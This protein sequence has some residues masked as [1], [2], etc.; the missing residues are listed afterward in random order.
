MATSRV[1]CASF[2]IGTSTTISITRDNKAY[3]HTLTY[4]FG[5]AT[6]TIAT[7]T[8]QTTVV[9]NPT[10]STL[11]AQIPNAVSGYGTIT[12]Q[13]YNG[14]TLVGTSTAGF[15]AYAVKSNC[16]PTVAA[17]IVDTN[18][19]TRNLTG[20]DTSGN[21]TKLIRYMS[22]PRVTI[23]AT[24]KNSATIK[25]YQIY[26]PGGLMATTSPYTFDTTYGAEWRCTAND[27]RG[28]STTTSYTTAFVEYDPCHFTTPPVIKRTESTSTTATITLKGYCFKGNFGA[29]SNTL[30][31]K[32]RY[33]T[34]TGSYGSYVSVTPTWNTDGTFTATAN[35]PNLS[36]AEQYTFEVIAQDKLTSFGDGE[37][38][39]LTQGIG[40]LRIAKDYV[41]AKNNLIVGDKDNED[42]RCFKARRKREGI[43]YDANFGAGFGGGGITATME[44]N[45]I[46]NGTETKLAR[47]DLR[48]DS[49]LYNYF[50]NMSVA[51]IMSFAPSTVAGGLQGNL[52]LN[53]GNSEPILIQWG[54]VSVTPTA[55]NTVFKQAINFAKQFKGLPA[56]FTEKSTGGPATVFANAGDITSTGFSMYLQRTSVTA[57]S[58]MWIAIGNGADIMPE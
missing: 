11:Y 22:K 38:I 9:W 13:T 36:L 17:T 54:R 14:N 8:T 47:Y 33:K 27:S 30:A 23:T 31:L 3:T 57:T 4:K 52:L 53:G 24:P 49:F 25:T 41:M 48:K 18:E 2:N 1:A 21:N 29:S 50:T 15:Y 56:V 46:T 19:K 45:Q 39:L 20:S 34:S 51:E 5:N 40:D 35:V 42:W 26:N 58:I 32:Y 28:Y 7:K 55:A 37:V 44:V 16:L 10:A 43:N 12:C 6:G